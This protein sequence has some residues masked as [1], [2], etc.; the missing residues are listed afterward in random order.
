MD[1]HLCSRA[2]LLRVRAQPEEPATLR[3]HPIL[4]TTLHGSAL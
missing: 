4:H 3:K 1:K 2:Q